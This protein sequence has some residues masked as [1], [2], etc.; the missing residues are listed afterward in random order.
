MNYLRKSKT[1]NLN[2]NLLRFRK[3]RAK[4]TVPLLKSNKKY[5]NLGLLS[6][7]LLLSIVGL[8]T[9]F[10]LIQYLFYR[11]VRKNLEPFV[12]EHD[13]LVQ[14]IELKNKQLSE[15]KILNNN[16]IDSITSIR[17]S[18]AILSEISKLIPKSIVLRNIAVKE[19]DLELK[20]VVNH[21]DGL[22]V[23]NLFILELNSSQFLNEGTVKLIK[24]SKEGQSSKNKDN[25]LAFIIK[26]NIIQDLTIVNKKYLKEIGSYGL[27]KRIDKIKKRGLIKWKIIFLIP[28][29][30]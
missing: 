8:I 30:N 21:I 29:K 13:N 27:F 4:D 16:L 22:E 19:N 9:S 15:V 2:N 3:D 12:I 10:L 11:S 26:A 23:I 24:A 5:V 17:S 14:A 7:G 1:T 25:L 6:G 28:K 20:G 18:S